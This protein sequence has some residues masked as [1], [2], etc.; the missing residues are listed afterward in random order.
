MVPTHPEHCWEGGGGGG[1]GGGRR[2]EGKG[3]GGEGRGGRGIRGGRMPQVLCRHSP[4]GSKDGEDK[5]VFVEGV[6]VLPPEYSRAGRGANTNQ[7]VWGRVGES[8]RALSLSHTP[9]HTH[10][11]NVH[12]P[13]LVSLSLAFL[14]FAQQS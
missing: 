9:S 5:L 4:C 1:G 14:L 13:D 8:T 2:G 3:G 6:K 10:T 12:L 7:Q 11:T